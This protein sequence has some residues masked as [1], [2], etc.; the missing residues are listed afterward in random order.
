MAWQSVHTKAQS[1]MV[2]AL[3]GVRNAGRATEVVVMV[4]AGVVYITA[5]DR[6]QRTN[7]GFED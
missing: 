2:E 1:G 4:K 6:N 7:S 5:P 3:S